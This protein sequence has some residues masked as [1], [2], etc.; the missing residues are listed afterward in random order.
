MWVPWSDDPEKAE[1][2]EYCNDEL[3]KLMK[4]YKE[5]QVKAKILHEKRK[6][7]AIEKNIRESE[8][9]KMNNDGIKNNKEIENNEEIKNNEEIENNEEIKS[10]I[11]IDNDIINNDIT[12]NDITN[13]ELS[14]DDSNIEENIK[15]E[16]N[17]AREVFANLKNKND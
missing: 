2:C 10:K 4:A 5:N 11:E 6:N 12:N 3:N 1:D 13:N 17:R 16:F 15:D 7:E 14:V 9:R 8:E